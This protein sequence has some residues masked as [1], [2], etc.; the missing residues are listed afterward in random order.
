MTSTR[1]DFEQAYRRWRAAASAPARARLSSS[2]A[3]AEGPE[4]DAIVALGPPA[5]PRILEAMERDPDAHFLV[6]ALERITGRRPGE[7]EL[8]SARAR[9]G[10]PLGNQ[11]LA[12][13]WREWWDAR[14]GEAR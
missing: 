9:F 10:A 11:Q 14:Q 8:A 4:L 5:V 2:A 3:V 12:V 1:D 7:D 13:L 6:L